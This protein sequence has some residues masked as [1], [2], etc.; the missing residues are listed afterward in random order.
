MTHIQNDTKE[1]D[2]ILSETIA[3]L[4]EQ[5]PVPFSD[6]TLETVVVGVFFT[7]VKLS[8]GHGGICF[9]P[10]DL[11][12]QAVCCTTSA[13]AMPFCGSMKGVSVEEI[14]THS[15]SP[16]PLVRGVII[17][18]VNALSSWVFQHSPKERYRVEDDTDAFDLL[19]TV[20]PSR[21]VVVVG[22]LWPVVHRLRSRGV[23]YRI[24]ELNR[25][26]LKEEELPFLSSPKIRMRFLHR[27]AEW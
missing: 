21:P 15:S 26:A 2:L 18:V 27:P 17:S 6:I 10:V 12:P 20:D 22:A 16:A 3:I 13:S 8:N 24:F 4:R 5:L 9:T 19:D 11:I 1:K 23:P 7:G 25:D 14:L